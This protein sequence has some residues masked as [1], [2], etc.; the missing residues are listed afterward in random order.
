MRQT[1]SRH[2]PAIRR[3]LALNFSV[4]EAERP[5]LGEIGTRLEQHFLQIG[6]R[7]EKLAQL[8]E[9][10]VATGEHLLRLATG[11]A[12]GEDQLHEA[13]NVLQP[14]IKV[15]DDCLARS[16]EVVEHLRRHQQLITE[17]R[18]LEGIMESVVAPLRFIQVA[19]R[20]E[21]SVLDAGVRAVFVSLTRDIEQ[22]HEQVL[23]LFSEQF[24]SLE[25]AESQLGALVVRLGPQIQLHQQA[26]VQ[27]KAVI[28]Q[29]LE[30][31][32]LALEE[33]RGRDVR[34]A[35]AAHGLQT[36]VARVI[37]AVQFEDITRQKLK[38]VDDALVGM[39]QR[40]AGA[41]RN[42]WPAAGAFLRETGEVQVGQVVAVEA[43]LSQA[44][45]A[46]AEAFD[47]IIERTDE[48]DRECLTLRDFRT[49]SVQ[50]DGV[51]QVVL[52]SLD[53]LAG[54][55]RQTFAIQSEVYETLKPLAG[56]A[57]DLTGA[58]RRLSQS[59]RIIALNAQIQAAQV[60]VGTGLEVLS[61]RTCQIADEASV[62]NNEA[63]AGLD[64]L[65]TGFDSLVAECKEL[66]DAVAAQQQWLEAEAEAVKVRLHQHRDVTLDT[67]QK[68]GVMV[69]QT[70]D[71]ARAAVE[72]LPFAEAAN[73]D[74]EQLVGAIQTVVDQTASFDLLADS[75]GAQE[76]ARLQANYTVASERA[77]HET[78]L[79]RKQAAT[80]GSA[81]VGAI[82]SAVAAA[83]AAADCVFFQADEPPTN[84]PTA[85]PVAAPVAAPPPAAAPAPMPL[86]DNIELF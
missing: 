49:I 59:I 13:I 4:V 35:D 31:L 36:A 3:Q 79:A 21:S 45:L 48:V 50:E 73:A 24:K 17:V 23:N 71:E 1:V 32:R 44:E 75:Q 85:A 76:S 20:I 86:G 8:S 81:P 68:F 43:E 15:L 53:E 42:S 5:V 74:L 18:H 12:D 51:V 2:N 67:F 66:Q 64:R 62:A 52:N 14:P 10:V 25:L 7:L 78:I 72:H 61:Q 9:D 80:A 26:A 38:H 58:M 63:A 27:K 69:G 30:G 70:R 46:I 55:V 54:L 77:I 6:T 28:A 60:G 39:G 57:S 82:V 83:P 37:G 33:N 41:D 47:A 84:P 11:Q 65:I 40:L 56:M 22:L 34:L 29:T 16:A 19:F